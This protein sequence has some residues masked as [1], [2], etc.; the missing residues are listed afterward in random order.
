MAID[1][2][3]FRVLHPE[4]VSIPTPSDLIDGF[5]ADAL[6]ELDNTGLFDDDASLKDQA[7]HNLA[8]HLLA[9]SPFGKSVRMVSDKGRTTYLDTYER[10]WLHALAG[11]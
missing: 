2:A 4:F 7:Q 8:A 10:L 9:T 5:L 3:A 6:T 11:V 1:E